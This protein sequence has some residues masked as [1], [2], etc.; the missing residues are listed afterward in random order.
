MNRFP[1]N[2]GC[3]CVSTCSTDT[4]YPKAEMQKKKK[5][6]IVMSSLL[7]SIAHALSIL[8]REWK[9][10]K[11]KKKHNFYDKKGLLKT[12]IVVAEN[13]SMLLKIKFSCVHWPEMK[14]FLL[15]QEF[16]LSCSPNSHTFIETEE[17]HCGK[18][19]IDLLCSHMEP[20]WL[21]PMTLQ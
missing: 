19:W 21:G 13:L 14:V 15:L 6:K 16:L 2:L 20:A 10:K 5:K 8:Y 4:R 17:M 11:K 3:G 18:T 7:Y 1:P 12:F 9:K